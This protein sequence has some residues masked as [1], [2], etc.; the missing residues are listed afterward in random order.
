ML[1]KKVLLPPDRKR[2][3]IKEFANSSRHNIQNVKHAFFG[4]F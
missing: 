3:E 1:Y 4:H 2:Y